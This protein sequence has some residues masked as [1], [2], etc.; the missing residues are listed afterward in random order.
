MEKT[1]MKVRLL[2]RIQ[3]PYSDVV[4]TLCWFW[5]VQT[6]FF[7]KKKSLIQAWQKLVIV[8]D[9][10]QNLSYQWRVP[11]LNEHSIPAFCNQFLIL[12]IQ[13][14]V[15]TKKAL[16]F[17]ICP[18]TRL[19]SKASWERSL[20]KVRGEFFQNE[21]IFRCQQP[22]VS[23]S[24]LSQSHLSFVIDLF[25]SAS[26]FLCE[27]LCLQWPLQLFPCQLARWLKA[28]AKANI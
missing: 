4:T 2:S 7:G 16:S 27:H 19:I 5:F 23:S 24:R 28:G 6:W 22:P 9:L 13:I 11:N 3:F 26:E 14:L 8:W 12:H 1:W 21:T 18:N 15:G 25:A 17:D 20:T 10:N